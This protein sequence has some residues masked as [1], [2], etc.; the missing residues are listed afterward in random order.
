MIYVRMYFFRAKFK[1]VIAEQQKN[2][3]GFSLTRTLTAA[4]HALKQ[5]FT[6]DPGVDERGMGMAPPTMGSIHTPTTSVSAPTKKKKG[7]PINKD[8]IKRID[9]GGVGLINP[10]GWYDGNTPTHTPGATPPLSPRSQSPEP[11][12][13]LNGESHK[14]NTFHTSSD[15]GTGSKGTSD[16]SKKR[17]LDETDSGEADLGNSPALLGSYDLGPKLS[18]ARTTES[19]TGTGTALAPPSTEVYRRPYAGTPVE[20]DAFPRSKTIAFDEPDDGFNHELNPGEYGRANYP[21]PR[22]PTTQ[23]NGLPWTATGVSGGFPRTYS[24]R[25]TT[26]RKV[27]TKFS[28]FGGFPTPIEMLNR[29]FSKAFPRV[30]TKLTETVTMPR[31]NTIT[32]RGS[33][34]SE[35]ASRQVPYISFSAVVGRNSNFKG[36]TEE[37]MDELGGVEYRALKLLFWI[38]LCYWLFLPIAGATIIAPYIAAQGRY[39]HIFENQYKHVRIPWFAFFQAYSGFTNLGMSLVDLSVLPFQG[40]Y[41]MNCGE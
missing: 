37:Q 18:R 21:F 34:H 14:L 26:S 20:E 3:S 38:V 36:L 29:G 25:P 24:L 27:E 17:S 28:G 35:A 15:P 40:A 32:G 41:L 9:G 16:E 2:R 11:H 12:A 22:V 19:I 13:S 33:I 1:H 23:S 39:D 6:R 31:T 30:S 10:M 5:R 8:M 4:P 7:G